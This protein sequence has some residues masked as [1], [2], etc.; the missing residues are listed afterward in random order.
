M[1]GPGTKVERA[2]EQLPGRLAAL[3]QA[4]QAQAWRTGARRLA[5]ESAYLGIEE[6]QFQRPDGYQGCY[7]CL[8]VPG[9]GA[10]VAACHQGKILLVREY[11]L[12]LDRIVWGLPGGRSDSGD[13]AEATARRELEEETGLIID[14][15]LRPLTCLVPSAAVTNHTIHTFAARVVDPAALTRQQSEIAGLHWLSLAEVEALLQ[16]DSILDAP[17]QTAIL[18]LLLFHRDWLLS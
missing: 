6:V 10:M 13:D 7:Y 15:P 11:R 18:Q 8:D 2:P 14:G 12:P 5:Y 1:A 9:H 4:D 16:N 3:E 17:S